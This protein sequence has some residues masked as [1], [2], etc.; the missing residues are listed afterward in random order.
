MVNYQQQQQKKTTLYTL[1]SITLTLLSSIGI[2]SDNRANVLSNRL[3]I[4]S[5]TITCLNF[6]VL[7]FFFEFIRNNLKTLLD[8]K[9]F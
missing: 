8:T 2:S 5:S 1:Y 4:T 9:S 7:D 3:N 6:C